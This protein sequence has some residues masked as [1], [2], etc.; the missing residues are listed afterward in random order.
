MNWILEQKEAAFSAAQVKIIERLMDRVLGPVPVEVGG[1]DGKPIQFEEARSRLA[2][3]L[4]PL[5]ADG[6]EGSLAPE[7]KPN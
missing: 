4:L 7:S 3:L 2:G 1:I 5:V 6:E